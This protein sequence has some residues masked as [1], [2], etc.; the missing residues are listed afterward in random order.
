MLCKGRRVR[1]WFNPAVP[2]QTEVPTLNKSKG[3]SRP[4]RRRF[5]NLVQSKWGGAD[6]HFAVRKSPKLAVKADAMLFGALK[7]GHLKV[8]S[9]G[10]EHEPDWRLCVSKSCVV[11]LSNVRS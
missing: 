4:E 9:V 10:T 7:A 3:S 6:R 2:R 1:E 5:L 11:L 8:V